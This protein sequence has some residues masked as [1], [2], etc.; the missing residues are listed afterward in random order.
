MWQQRTDRTQKGRRDEVTQE[1]QPINAK[2]KN[3]PHGL[4]HILLFTNYIYM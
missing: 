4:Q 2:A 3:P 1:N